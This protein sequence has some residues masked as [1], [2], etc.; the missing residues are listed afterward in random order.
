MKSFS[1]YNPI[2][3]T[4]W[5]LCITSIAMFSGYPIIIAVSFLSSIILFIIKNKRNHEK[6]HG[7]FFILFIILALVNPLISHNGRTVLF[8]FN[9]N[10]ITLEACLYGINSSAMIIGILYW[11]RS[12]SIIMTSEKILYITSALSP[13]ISLIISMS[14]RYIPLFKKQLKKITDAQKAMGLFKDDNIIDE[15]LG[16]I[17]IFSILITWALE[18]GIITADSMEARGY[19]TKKRT[20]MKKF[21]FRLSDIFFILISILLTLITLMSI[22]K[23]QFYFI[24]YPSISYVKLEFSGLLGLVSYFILSILPVITEIK[25]YFKWKYLTSKI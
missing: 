8:I 2:T 24:F 17:R 21:Y 11:F 23:G 1:E 7:F 12:F 19:G 3:I 22:I 5:F 10:P 16:R 4:I 9:D 6:F 25:V 14:L 13:K 18:N 15:I 20:N